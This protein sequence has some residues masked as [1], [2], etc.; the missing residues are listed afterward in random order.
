MFDD[1]QSQEIVSYWPSVSDLFMTMFVIGLAMLGVIYYV[2][3]PKM[4]PGDQRNIVAAV[5]VDMQNIRKPVNRMRESLG[6]IPR[7]RDTQPAKEVLAGLDDTSTKVVDRL[8]DCDKP[9]LILIDEATTKEYRF[10]SGSAVMSREFLQGLREKEFKKLADEIHK[11]NVGGQLKVDTLEIIGHTD[12]QA[13]AKKGNLDQALAAY[14]S[15]KDTSF[16]KLEAGSNNDLGL[17]RALAVRDAWNDFVND[18]ATADELRKITVR[19]YSAGQ[20]IPEVGNAK[21]PQTYRVADKQYRRI[22]VRLTKLK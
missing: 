22:E 12:G 14:L 15:G 13:I 6:N 11:R 3:S 19:C 2:L 10:D 20:T 17:L 16:Q 21:D 8:A 18:H 5:G 7:L 1:E 4:K 9:F